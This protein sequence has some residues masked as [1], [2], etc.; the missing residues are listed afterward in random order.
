ME[1]VLV[2]A[3]GLV[4]NEVLHGLV[5]NNE[6]TKIH[7]LVRKEFEIKSEK[8][9][10]H[11]V[12]FENE[13]NLIDSMVGDVIICCIGTTKAK[14]P[15]ITEYEKIDRDIPIRLAKIGNHKK[16]SQFHLISAIGANSK[17]SINYNRIKGEAESGVLNSG[18]S[19]IYIYRP[20][21]LIGKRNEFRLGELIAQ[22]IAFIFD[23]FLV[24]SWKKYHSVKANELANA[25]ITNVLK[26][27]T[28]ETN[29]TYRFYGSW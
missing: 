11:I 28:N 22:K 4:G 21:L 18:I 26:N 24:G 13:Q 19:S 7:V 5:H 2:G 3:S 17:S 6:I 10:I 29:H 12:D 1:V 20:G 25:I 14:T 27:K 16:I 8:A 9:V 15:S 23:L